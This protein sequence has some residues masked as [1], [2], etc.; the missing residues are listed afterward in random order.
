MKV[1]MVALRL[2]PHFAGA[3]V[4]ATYLAREL[5]QSGVDVEFFTDNDW[6]RSSHGTFEGVPIYRART[7]TTRLSNIKEVFFG[8]RLV[9][10]A[11]RRKYDI[12]HF[13]SIPAFATFA[14]PLLKLSRKNV[15][16][17]LT[18]VGSDDPLTRTRRKLGWLTGLFLKSVDVFACISGK[19]C[20]L[21]REAGIPDQ[22]I[23]LIPNGLQTERF[24]P[25]GYSERQALR[26]AIGFG[27]YKQ[28]FISIGKVEK[29]KG[30]DR[31]L[32]AWR[33]IRSKL[34][35][36]CLLIIGPGNSKENAFFRE[37]EQFAAK[38][39]IT[40]VH[41]LGQIDDVSPFVR[42]ADVFLFC[43]RQ[44]GFGTVLIEAAASGVPVVAVNIDGVTEDILTDDRIG[45][46][47]KR[48]NPEIFAHEAIRLAVESDLS[49]LAE[50]AEEVRRKF[51]IRQIAQHY[52]EVYGRLM[53][54]PPVALLPTPD[55]LDVS[56][57]GIR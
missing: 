44:E 57:T 36:S 16:V 19:L 49:V 10:Y 43:S 12:V 51:D 46:I 9:L 56:S 18:L 3:G 41:F 38:Q 8:L 29:R 31:L 52:I 47:V 22:K 39:S 40:D 28:M 54:Y 32:Q 20:A 4:Q 35:E 1:L 48:F 15:L 42:A 37:L 55:H 2:P 45:R 11:W 34:P 23:E 14:C 53:G 6:Q 50:A 25:T 27:R 26:S 30:Y 24:L 17:K 33:F 13:H 21:C 5:R 7:F